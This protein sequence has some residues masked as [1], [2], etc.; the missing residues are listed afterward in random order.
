MRKYILVTGSSGFIG[1]HLCKRLLK[2]NKNFNII[3][4]DNMNSYYDLKLKID[5]LKILKKHKNFIFFKYDLEDFI[6]LNNLF[7]KFKIEKVINLAAQ[8]GVRNSI[9]DPDT[10]F[11]YNVNGFYNILKLCVNFQIK[12][13]VYASSSSVYGSSTK[14]PFNEQ[15]D[16][17][18]PKSFYAAT[19]KMNEVMA[20]SFS[21]IYGLKV[22]GM[23]FFTV[24]GP[25]GRPDMS[26]YKFIEAI[27]NKKEIELFNNGNHFRDFTYIDDCIDGIILVLNRKMQNFHKHEIFNIGN[28]NS[29]PLNLFLDKIIE[30]TNNRKVKIK[31]LGMQLGD[32]YKTH[33]SIKKINKINNFKPKY[34]IE[35]GIKLF[36]DWYTKYHSI[37]N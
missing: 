29:R 2:S 10:Y 25:Y 21:E 5:R 32:V 28:G 15:I 30:S 37:K 34:S 20:H 16:T 26:L 17:S 6:K 35:M 3:G 8:A 11:K 31:K 33:S 27:F 23:R 18:S 36:I 22:S 13:L 1:F 14:Y 19:K 24:Y 9:Y 12:H 7:K 4:V